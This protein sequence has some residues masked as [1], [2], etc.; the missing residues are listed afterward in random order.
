MP[1]LPLLHQRNQ[2]LRL[3]ACALLGLLS[4]VSLHS[5]AQTACT[6]QPLTPRA[7]QLASIALTEH[8]EFNGHRMSADGILWQFGA[9]ESENEALQGE[10]GNMVPDRMAWRR[11]WEYWRILAKHV[12]GQTDLL[13][14]K[15]LPNL[16]P[17]RESEAKLQPV[18]LFAL[19]AQLATLPPG[20][21]QEALQQAAVRAAINDSA[22]SAAFI[23]AIMDKAGLRDDEFT[24]SEAHAHYIRAAFEANRADAAHHAAPAGSHPPA[25][26]YAY[27]ACDPRHTAPQ[28]GDLLCYARGRNRDPLNGFDDWETATRNPEFFAKSHCELVVGQQARQRRLMLV[29]GNVQQSVMLRELRL[30]RHLRL[31]PSHYAAASPTTL[32]NPPAPASTST[33]TSAPAPACSGAKLCQRQDFNRQRWGVLLQLQATPQPTAPAPTAPTLPSPSRVD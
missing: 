26:P 33:S 21:V 15:W 28:L 3:A 31:H 24:Y 9:V 4:L 20:P 8:R 2:R 19:E 16:L 27:R 18:S 30:D 23:S 25:S 22:W 7:E 1:F 11:V 12:P 5:H 6:P 17:Q 29:S 10:N 13:P 14:V 32:A